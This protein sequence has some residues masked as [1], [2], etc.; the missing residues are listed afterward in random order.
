MVSN[1]E[2]VENSQE[3]V[4]CDFDQGCFSTVFWTEPR[5]EGFMEVV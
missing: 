3:E 5:L 4:V 2:A 1:S